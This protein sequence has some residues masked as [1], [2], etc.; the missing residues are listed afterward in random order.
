MLKTDQVNVRDI[1]NSKIPNYK[2][3]YFE[4]KKLEIKNKNRKIND[5]RCITIAHHWRG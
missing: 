4:V 1:T 5:N 3:N 2:K